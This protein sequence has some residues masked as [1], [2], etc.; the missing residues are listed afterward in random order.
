MYKRVITY[1]LLTLGLA[2]TSQSMM[3]YTNNVVAS[4]IKAASVSEQSAYVSNDEETANKE[5]SSALAEQ[6]AILEKKVEKEADATL[7]A[8]NEAPSATAAKS[9]PVLSRGGTGL[10][11]SQ[12]QTSDKPVE[13]K[14][15]TYSSK[16]ELVDWYKSGQTVFSVGTVAEVT[17]LATGKTFKAKRT[18]GTNHA[19]AEALT[20]QD[21]SIIKSIWGGFSWTR[22]PVILTIGGKKYAAS[23]SAMPHAGL[24]SAAAY[25]VIN[26]RSEG[27]G[28]GENLDVIKGNGMDGHFD[29]H[30][31]NS[32]RHKDNK[33]DPEHQ[34]AVLRAAGK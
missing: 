30:F 12:S 6:Q 15:T 16:I 21:T 7:V 11:S 33:E 10:T 1:F 25:A 28:R 18:M 13:K 9:A 27:Y 20:K 4:H 22:R 5:E 32:K 8:S 26:N 14:Q 29:I 2:I 17:D 23:M 31:L 24:D 34:A 19:D 3:Q